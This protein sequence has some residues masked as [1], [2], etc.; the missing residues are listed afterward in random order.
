MV[1]DDRVFLWTRRMGALQR[2]MLGLGCFIGLVCLVC[3]NRLGG[4]GY[5]I[6]LLFFVCLF[7]VVVLF[8]LE[9]GLI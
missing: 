3:F 4:F 8:G 6:N 9:L 2:T 5:L 1:L 7:F